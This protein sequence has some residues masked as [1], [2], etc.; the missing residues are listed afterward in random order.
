[1]Y[2][3]FWFVFILLQIRAISQVFH[4]K[5]LLPCPAEKRWKVLS[6]VVTGMAKHLALFIGDP[7][8]DGEAVAAMH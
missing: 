7:N 8:E 3:H 6:A 4:G 2:F 1:M 5:L